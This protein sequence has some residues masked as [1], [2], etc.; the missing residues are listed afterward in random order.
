MVQL[1]SPPFL[2]CGLVA[3]ALG[4]ESAETNNSVMRS[5]AMRRMV[6]PCIAPERHLLRKIPARRFVVLIEVFSPG[7]FLKVEEDE[8]HEQNV[9]NRIALVPS[10]SAVPLLLKHVGFREVFWIQN[11]SK[12]LPLDYL[13][14][15]RMTFIA[16][17]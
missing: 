16:V 17:K 7:G 13:T 5:K 6:I 12:N 10:K 15:A 1:G 2:K 8:V 11:A 4:A 14:G 3:I 9:S